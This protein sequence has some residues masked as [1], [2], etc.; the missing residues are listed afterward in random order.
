MTL[1]ELARESGAAGV[2]VLCLA[3]VALAA[4]ACGLGWLRRS[5]LIPRPLAGGGELGPLV[6]AAKT[7]P[8]L[9]AA[10]LVSSG[11]EARKAKAAVRNSA[12]EL[13]AAPLACAHVLLVCCV[14]S[15]MV[16]IVGT[17]AGMARALAALR[18][19]ET[20]ASFLASALLRACSAGALGFAVGAG[21]F[22]LYAA[23]AWKLERAREALDEFAEE[24]GAAP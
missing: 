24:V 4:F 18:A 21:T 10:A 23:V 13:L 6:D 3:A 1:G 19:A 22:V 16:G 14:V 9:L 17:S 12:R 8:G 15:P 5:R 2:L 7:V 20:S 11:G